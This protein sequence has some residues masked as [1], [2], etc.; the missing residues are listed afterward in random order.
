MNFHIKIWFFMANIHC[1]FKLL[2]VFQILALPL[3]LSPKIF[4]PMYNLPL[5]IFR[6]FNMPPLAVLSSVPEAVVVTPGL[7]V[8]SLLV[9]V[10]V[11]ADGSV[12]LEFPLLVDPY[13][14]G[15]LVVTNEKKRFCLRF[16]KN[17][18]QFGDWVQLLGSL[19]DQKK[20]QCIS[21]RHANSWFSGK[22]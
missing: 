13:D 2:T 15:M 6:P 1:V 3:L 5:Q 20:I 7:D 18:K 22:L 16:S 11:A 17:M 10:W 8:T 9:V 19:K 4:G 12:L 14:E 21:F